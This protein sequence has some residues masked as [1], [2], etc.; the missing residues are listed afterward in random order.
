MGKNNRTKKVSQKKQFDWSLIPKWVFI[1]LCCLL[2]I[3]AIAKIADAT[4]YY[5]RE[6]G[7]DGSAGTSWATAW[8][9]VDKVNDNMS[10]GDSVFFGTGTYY[11]FEIVPPSGGGTAWTVYACSTYEDG[12]DLSGKFLPRIRSGKV[13]TGTWTVHAGNIWKTFFANDSRDTY[14]DPP[15]G[16][17]IHTLVNVTRDSIFCSTEALGNITVGG[18]FDYKPSVGSL[19]VWNMGN[20]D[21]NDDSIYASI[22]PV[23]YHY[24]SKRYIKYIGLNLEGGVQGVT[25]FDDETFD[26]IEF[27]YCHMDKIS[28]LDHEN[29]AI[30]FSEAGATTSDI[31][32][33]ACSLGAGIQ[34]STD[35]LSGAFG[36]GGTFDWYSTSDITVESCFVYSTGANGILYK[37]NNNGNIVRYNT[38]MGGSGLRGINMHLNADNIVIVGN[39]LIGNFDQAAISVGGGGGT[40]NMVC[41]NNTIVNNNS[42]NIHLGNLDN[43]GAGSFTGTNEIKY[44]LVYNYGLSED[45][46]INSKVVGY[47]ARNCSSCDIDIDSNAYYSATTAEFQCSGNANDTWTAWTSGG[48]CNEDGNSHDPTVDYGLNMSTYALPD[49]TSLTMNFSHNGKTWT[50][51]GSEEEEAAEAQVRNKL[52]G[53]K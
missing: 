14:G 26:H 8:A 46:P 25:V 33:R 44:N 52:K 42:Y 29:P 35:G 50:V 32:I 24:P 51:Y 13:V 27:H 6:A 10:K 20:G 2:F 21:P 23:A 37:I 1:I 38:I 49:T 30:F 36:H 28:F 12:Q 53:W 22:W 47:D 34:E 9:T 15:S 43:D 5:V 4:T 39:L 31:L 17:E 3:G 40:N 7:N 41:Y 48:D 19:Y 18:E 45:S 16:K 11:N